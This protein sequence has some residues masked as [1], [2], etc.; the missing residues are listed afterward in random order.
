MNKLL[1]FF[2]PNNFIEWLIFFI[3]VVVYWVCMTILMLEAEAITEDKV[4]NSWNILEKIS[5]FPVFYLGVD[6]LT[7]LIFNSLIW[8]L[9]FTKLFGYFLKIIQTGR[10]PLK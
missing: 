6:P 4:D 5:A 3:V 9:A 8:G 1:K 7:G 2:L 10:T